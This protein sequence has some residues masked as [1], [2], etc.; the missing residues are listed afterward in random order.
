MVFVP[1]WRVEY[2]DAESAVQDYSCWGEVSA[3]N[4]KVINAIF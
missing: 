1:V 2:K 4:G 3:V